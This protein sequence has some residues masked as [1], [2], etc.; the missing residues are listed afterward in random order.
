[1][2]SVYV[3]NLVRTWA[4]L[5]AT[6]YY[7]TI[8]Q[9]QNPKDALWFTVDFEVEGSGT[10]TVCGDTYE[11]GIVDLVFCG[12][13]GIGDI[14][15]LTAAEADAKVFLAQADPA[16]RF[17]IKRAMPPVEFSGGDADPNYRAV[18][19]LEYEYHP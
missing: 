6:P 5:C 8:N 7:D 4:A 17:T 18:V 14:A 9:E 13:P 11:E 12:A 10:L 2:S 19:G 3:R 15:L 1:M 16:G